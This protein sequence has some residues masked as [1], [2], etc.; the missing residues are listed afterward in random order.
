MSNDVNNLIEAALVRVTE[1][2]WSEVTDSDAS[3]VAAFSAL[4][5]LHCRADRAT[6]DAAIAL[7]HEG[8]P[9]RRRLGAAL[10]A[11]LGHIS[12]DHAPVFVEERF[13]ALRDLMA[14]ERAGGDRVSVLSE[15][16]FA[17]MHLRDARG[18][19]LAAGLA[20]HPSADVRYAVACA[21]ATHDEH[22][23]TLIALSGDDA[24]PVR[25]WATFGLGAMTKLDTP[26]LRAA[27]RARLD[28]GDPDVRN[29][30]IFGLAAR[31]DS[32]A[33]PAIMRELE[34]Q[35]AVPLFEAAEML[36]DPSLAPALR[37]VKEL[38]WPSYVD[39]AWARALA[40]CEG[41]SRKE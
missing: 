3:S 37:A 1:E 22:A 11:E 16:C 29:E 31:G 15:V 36:A 20:A 17:F 6:L 24:A 39:N 41:A 23:D 14:E 32:V 28:D 13:A 9:R 8:E 21:L 4:R 2:G 35:Y 12:S 7:T 33:S 18:V 19:R 34:I 10:L 30:A 27:L 38:E 5:A 40:A 26:A 25:D